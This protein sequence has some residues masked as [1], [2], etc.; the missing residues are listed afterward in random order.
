MQSR[1]YCG[2]IP[3]LRFIKGI[4]VIQLKGVVCTWKVIVQVMA[5]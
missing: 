3:E 1:I 5:P 2:V 4:G